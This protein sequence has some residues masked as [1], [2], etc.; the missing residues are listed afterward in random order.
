MSSDDVEVTTDHLVLPPQI[1]QKCSTCNV[2]KLLAENFM[3]KR[4][5]YLKTCIRCRVQKQTSMGKRVSL[6]KQCMLED[7]TELEKKDY[8]NLSFDQFITMKKNEINPLLKKF[9]RQQI[10]KFIENCEPSISVV[11][12]NIESD[13]LKE[14]IKIW[15]NDQYLQYMREE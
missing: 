15:L 1:K 9:S 11:M 7:S 8:L 12:E 3:S 2:E 14:I 13:Q 4:G 5:V 10:I 6:Y